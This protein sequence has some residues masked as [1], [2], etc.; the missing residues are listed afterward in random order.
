VPTGVDDEGGV[1]EQFYLSQPLASA[2]FPDL[3]ATPKGPRRRSGSGLLLEEEEWTF[4]SLQEEEWR[5][6][7][8]PDPAVV[9]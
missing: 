4:R 9:A 8:P 3:A 7:R 6:L 5:E 2:N 1:G